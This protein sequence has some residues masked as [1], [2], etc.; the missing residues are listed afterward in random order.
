MYHARAV[1]H[2]NLLPFGETRLPP[3]YPLSMKI[4]KI[5]VFANVSSDYIGFF[6]VSSFSNVVREMLFYSILTL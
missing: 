6:V 2:G 5:F 4:R 3:F 1:C